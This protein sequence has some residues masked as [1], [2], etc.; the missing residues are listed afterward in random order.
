MTF[1][2]QLE[3]A[4]K[5]TQ[6]HLKGHLT[7]QE[8]KFKWQIYYYT[9]A[10]DCYCNSSFFWNTVTDSCLC[11]QTN[12][13]ISLASLSSTQ[14]CYTCCFRITARIRGSAAAHITPTKLSVT[15]RLSARMSIPQS[16]QGAQFRAQPDGGR[17]ITAL[18][19]YA[20]SISLIHDTK[21]L[22]SSPYF[23]LLLLHFVTD[24]MLHQ[25]NELLWL[26]GNSRETAKTTRKKFRI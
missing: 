7:F 15:V 17:L 1:R 26:P 3:K 9:G 6:V 13:A 20:Y 19:T 4:W 5:T 12:P 11:Y 8:L 2:S 16:Q 14:N 10:K 22:I 21:C 25:G 24:N 18:G 23:L